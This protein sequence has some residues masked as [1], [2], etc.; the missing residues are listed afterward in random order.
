MNVDKQY[1][2]SDIIEAW[3]ATV[4]KVRTTV[5]SISAHYTFDIDFMF[6]GRNSEIITTKGNASADLVA[7]MKDL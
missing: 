1:S 3:L 7:K 6:T 5:V 2:V 4:S